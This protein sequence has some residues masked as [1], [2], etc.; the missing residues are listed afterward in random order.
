[1]IRWLHHILIVGVLILF[2][3]CHSTK[4]TVKHGETKGKTEVSSAKSNNAVKNIA[5][6]VGVS[7]S[8]IKGKKLYEFAGDWYGVPYKYGGCDKKGTDCSCL[9]I[10]LYKEV[11]KVTL[12]RTADEMMKHCNKLSSS[13]ANEGDLVFFKI[14]T[15]TVS[16]VG[17]LLKNNKFIHASTQKGVIINDINEP[18]YKKYFYCYGRVK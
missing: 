8:E 16:H 5:A 10:N 4:K 7:E 12:P 18:Y 3:H 13:K 1:M 2:F 15:K 14:G 17:V 9:T 11:Y 6:I